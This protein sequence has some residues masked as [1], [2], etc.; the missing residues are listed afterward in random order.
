MH[1]FS[2]LTTVQQHVESSRKNEGNL[3]SS[4]YHNNLL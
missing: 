4:E 2:F 3:C 1:L